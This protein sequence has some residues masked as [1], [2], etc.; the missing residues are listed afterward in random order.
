MIA[1]QMQP[2]LERL[3]KEFTA[4]F[5]KPLQ[6]ITSVNGNA[7]QPV[8]PAEAAEQT[9]SN[10]HIT[11]LPYADTEPESEDEEMALRKGLETAVTAA[12]DLFQLIDKQQLSLLGATTDLTGPTVERLIERYITE[13]LHD[14]ILFPRVC[15]SRKI[16]DAELEWKIR[17][18]EYLDISQVGITIKDGQSGKRELLTR[19]KKG[20]E[21]FRKLGVA[22]GPQEMLEVLLST[23]KTV[24]METADPLAPKV[25]NGEAYQN[26][27]KPSSVLAMNADTL[28][29][30]LLVVVVRAQ[31]R[32]LQARLVYMR[33]FIFIDDV[34][35]GELG[36]ALSTFEAVL[37]YL[38]RDSGGLRRASRRNKRLWQATKDGDLSVIREILEPDFAFLDD[39][40][41]TDEPET[42]VD[43]FD[44][45]TQLSQQLS[46]TASHESSIP[47]FSDENVPISGLS[48][49]N[50]LG[51]VF[52]FQ[53]SRKSSEG[54]SDLLIR[55]G[56]K[57][58]ME[59]RS[60]SSSSGHSFH[61]RTVTVDSRGSGMEGDT[62]IERLSATQDASG[63]SIVMMAIEYRQPQALLY[64][65]SLHDY[66]SLDVILDDSNDEGTSLLSAAVQ[67][68]DTQI[69]DIIL[70]FVLQADEPAKIKGYFEKP[71]HRGRTMAHYLFN[72]PFLISRIGHLVSWR[73]RDQNGQT[74]LFALCRSYD[75]SD[76]Y[77]MVD[78][79]L[80]A[81]LKSQEDGQMLHLDDHVDAKGNSILHVVNDANVTRRLLYE[82]D[83]DVNA[84]NDKHFTP[85]MVASKYGRVNMVRA[86]F[87]DPRVDLYAKELRGFTAVELA[88]DDEVRNKIDDLILLSNEP[89][90]DGRM[91]AVVRSFFVEDASVRLVL[92][93]GIESSPTTY[94]V[95]TCRRSL[96]DFENLAKW[97]SVEH[98]ASWIPS[99]KNTR[100]PFQMPSRPSRA[101]LRDIQCRLD[102]FLK[103]LLS[104]STFSTHEMLW[105]FFLVPDMQLDMMA[106]RSKKKAEM[107][108]E[109]L[110]EEV[111]PID[112]VQDVEVFVEHA[113]ETVLGVDQR[114][115]DVARRVNKARNTASGMLFC[116]SSIRV[117]LI[118][119]PTDF[120]DAHR[121]ASLTLSTFSFVPTSH[122]TAFSRYTACL[123]LSSSSPISRLHASILG[124]LSTI[125]A[126][127][128][129]LDRPSI[130]IQSLSSTQKAIARHETSVRRS[131][132]WPL[133]LLDDTRLKIQQDATEK[134][135]DSR[136]QADLLGREISASQQVIAGE[137]AGWQDQHEQM[138]KRM[139]RQFVK[140]M[141][142]KERDR[143]ESMKR[144]VRGVVDLKL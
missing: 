12:I 83:S 134:V 15:S 78:E 100:S 1:R 45:A 77:R 70:D 51:H 76:Y 63:D 91:T 27:E 118:V 49:S 17:Q 133:G 40:F 34:E 131:D 66:F 14:S 73:R 94:T 46:R 11:A 136:R 112:D 115:R 137:L 60:F 139:L 56:K 28:V 110:H 105:E 3:F 33:Q 8:Q 48:E 69:I 97:L 36:Y 68:G 25:G 142:I 53:N 26:G 144:A 111:E 75:N 61:S 129:S 127:L 54:S 117:S 6:P 116:H 7:V 24:A 13:Q 87:D 74:P 121:L 67:T 22:G 109:K 90:E 39:G 64:L 93:S 114:T 72:A 128:T 80:T 23:E 104:H 35:G 138:G 99:I 32:H 10:G 130:L 29:S 42:L 143:L 140:G 30:L 101:I 125:T 126:L 16:E 98:P 107:R 37:S 89:G 65:L 9:T 5:Q 84:I 108:I 102:T 95:T 96:A 120:A 86:F 88:K 4:G 21:E 41:A 103:V 113:R 19:L 132:R 20:V 81:A 50:S 18:M 123:A 119:R 31:I 59:T 79:G 62:S 58:M 43:E 2:G 106:E 57:V 135:E 71:D 141:V 55:K 92:K 52:P 82:C 47:A 124:I 122:L 44:H 38:A 85:L